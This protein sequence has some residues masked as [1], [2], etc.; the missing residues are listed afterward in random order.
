MAGTGLL[1][2]ITSVQKGIAVCWLG[3]AGW[4]VQAEG[5]LIGFDLDLESPGRRL[6]E[7]PIHAEVLAPKLDVLF[8]THGHGDHFNRPTC[9]VLAENGGC[10]FVIPANC[11]DTAGE[12]D[13]PKERIQV[14]RPREPFDIAGFHVEPQRALH[15]HARFAVNSTA[16]FDDCGYLLTLD[17]K[18]ILQPGD[19]VLLKDH[20]ELEHVDVLF[21]SPTEH[22]M[23]VE[24][25]ADLITT[26]DPEHVFPQHFATYIKTEQNRFWTK[27]YP[28]ELR[29]RLPE[30]M[31]RRF[32]KL[33]QGE[34]FLIE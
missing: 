24:R 2:E 29:A 12:C 26:L 15:G 7:P 31:Q 3:N 4:L 11:L 33:N 18:R 16:N 14:P 17:G 22:N 20:F 13:I 25:S 19:S 8:V 34:V 21:V 5:H 27:G 10:T 6:A 23:H 28:D 9:R 1:E 32:H 30:P